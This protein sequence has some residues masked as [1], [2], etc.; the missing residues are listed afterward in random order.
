MLGQVEV[1]RDGA[2]L[3]LGGRKQRA[4]LTSLLVRAGRVVSLDQLIDDLWP[5]DPPARAVATVAVT[6]VA[7]P[8][9]GSVAVTVALP[10]DT[11]VARPALAAAFETSTALLEDVHVTAEVTSVV[12]PSL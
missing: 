7:M 5:A 6:A 4:V 9:A 8:E 10:V 12:A 11:P 2:R 3:D 1:W